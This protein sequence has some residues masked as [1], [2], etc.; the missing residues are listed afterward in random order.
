MIIKVVSNIFIYTQNKCSCFEFKNY[1]MELFQFSPALYLNSENLNR[2][3]Y[4][5]TE[6]YLICLRLDTCEGKEIVFVA[7]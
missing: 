6:I 7:L 1:G 5:K 4:L 2:Y 3:T